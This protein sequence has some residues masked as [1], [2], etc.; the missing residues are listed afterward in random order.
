MISR[1]DVHAT[2]RVVTKLE[3][4]KKREKSTVIESSKY[5]G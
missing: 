3:R 2:E 1:F 5:G 4:T